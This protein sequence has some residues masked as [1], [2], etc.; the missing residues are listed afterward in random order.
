MVY[1]FWALTNYRD[2]LKLSKIF[3][4]AL[5]KFNNVH[6]R[7]NFFLVTTLI[8]F[9]IVKRHSHML[10]TFMSYVG[11]F[12]RPLGSWPLEKTSTDSHQK[13]KGKNLELAG[14][15]PLRKRV[16]GK[17]HVIIL[18]AFCYIL[19]QIMQT[20][21]SVTYDVGVCRHAIYHTKL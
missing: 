1:I 13:G 10:F 19:S 3:Y 16:F 21:W 5:L 9:I 2:L 17:T 15:P 11:V 4:N 18:N 14:Y 8:K 6:I 20:R 7:A 12:L